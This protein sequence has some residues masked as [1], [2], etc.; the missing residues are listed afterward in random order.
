[1]E[2]KP[3]LTAKDLRVLERAVREAATWRGAKTGSSDLKAFDA[4]IADAQQAIRR[5]KA[6]EFK[7]S[8]APGV[9]S[10][11]SP[12]FTKHPER[13]LLY[14]AF[15]ARLIQE[16]PALRSPRGLHDYNQA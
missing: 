5:I 9:E 4:F 16:C 2:Y 8:S 6:A 15:K 1:M 10:S 11:A 12:Y 3:L 7:G 14:Q 13:E